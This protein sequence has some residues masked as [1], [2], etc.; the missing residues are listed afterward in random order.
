MIYWYTNDD[1]LH[2]LFSNSLSSFNYIHNSSF[3]EE[4]V[5][6]EKKTEQGVDLDSHLN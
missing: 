2:V 6:I 4:P 5:F 3:V 1:L